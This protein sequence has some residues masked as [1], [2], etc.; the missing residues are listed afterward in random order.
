[1][2][3]PKIF[4]DEDDTDLRRKLAAFR[5][6][7]LVNTAVLIALLAF[8]FPAAFP[9]GILVLGA[10]VTNRWTAQVRKPKKDRHRNQIDPF[11]PKTGFVRK[12]R[13]RYPRS[14]I[15]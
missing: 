4:K 14:V 10:A 8:V 9:L 12:S 1:M 5:W 11:A 3:L 2:D 15:S 7:S 6:L 13:D